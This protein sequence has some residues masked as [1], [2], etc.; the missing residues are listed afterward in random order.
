[1][2]EMMPNANTKEEHKMENNKLMWLAAHSPFDTQAI[3]G[4]GQM[5]V[6]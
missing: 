4:M 5:G 1:M 6:K 2:G 3:C